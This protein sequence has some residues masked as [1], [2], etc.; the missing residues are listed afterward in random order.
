MEV[1]ILTA[2]LFVGRDP[3]VPP[4]VPYILNLA[5]HRHLDRSKF[6]PLIH[7]AP[8]RLTSSIGY[9]FSPLLGTTT[10]GSYVRIWRWLWT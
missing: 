9:A 6:L 7:P 8:A 3:A 5:S 1:R 10:V 4:G 2:P